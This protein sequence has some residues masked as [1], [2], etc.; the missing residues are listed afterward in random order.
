MQINKISPNTPV[1]QAKVNS[2]KMI[3]PMLKESG[4]DVFVKGNAPKAAVT[5]IGAILSFFGMGEAKPN[6]PDVMVDLSEE[7]IQKMRAKIKDDPVFQTFKLYPEDFCKEQVILTDRILNDEK[8]RSDKSLTT[9]L[10]DIIYEVSDKNQLR[11]AN[12]IL[13]DEKLYGD[14]NIRK[15]ALIILST[16]SGEEETNIKCEVLNKYMSSEKFYGNENVNRN[17]IKMLNFTN[18][19]E[20][21]YVVNKLLDK[22]ELRTSKEVMDRSEDFIKNANTTERFEVINKVLDN[23][24]LHGNNDILKSVSLMLPNI[25]NSRDSQIVMKVLNNKDLYSNKYNISK[26]ANILP[27]IT[28]DAHEEIVNK[29]F[30]NRE[31]YNNSSLMDILPTILPHVNAPESKMIVD[32]ILDN[33]RLAISWNL[34]SNLSIILGY[35]KQNDCADSYVRILDK[36][37]NNKKLLENEA[38]RDS[39]G[40][41]LLCANSHENRKIV[42]KVLNNEKLYGNKDIVENLHKMLPYTPRDANIQLINEFL[43]DKKLYENNL[44][45]KAFPMAIDYVNSPESYDIL[46]RVLH[47]EK[48]R[49]NPNIMENIT[50]ILCYTYNKYALKLAERIISD[51]NIYNNSTVMKALAKVSDLAISEYR[52]N[53][54]SKIVDQIFDN[55]NLYEDTNII[56]NFGNILTYTSK[57]EKYRVIEKILNEERLYKNCKFDEV[58]KMLRKVET[59]EEADVACKLLEDED[60]SLDA[61]TDIMVR[62]KDPF[63]KQYVYDLCQN[64]KKMELTQQNVAFLCMPY[65]T[66]TPEQLQRLNKVAGKENVSKLN[67]NDLEMACQIAE[68]YGKHNINEISAHCKKDLLRALISS[69]IGLFDVSD[70]MKQMFP[71]VPKNAQEYCTLLPALVRSM[72]IETKSLSPAQVKEFDKLIFELSDSLKKLSDDEFTSLKITQEYTKDEFIKNVR[73]VVKMLP[74]EER[75]KFYDYYGFELHH[76]RNSKT[77]FSIAG[78]PANLNNGEKLAQIKDSAT[79]TVVE[80]LRSDVIRFSENNLVQCDNKD[81]EYSLNKILKFLPELHTAIGKIQHPTHSFDIFKHSLKVLQK[82]SQDEKFQELNDSDKKIMML[83]A[84]L[85]DITKLE[86]SVDKTHPKEGAFDAYY[87]A[88]KFGLTREEEIKLFK[89]TQ[90]HEWLAYVN[91]SEIQGILTERLKSVAFELQ[92]DNLLDMA[93]IFT[94][95]DL[96]AVKSTDVFHDTKVGAGRVDLYGTSRS[97]GELADTYAEKIRAYVYEL[98]KTQ[99][100]LPVTKFPKASRINEVITHVNPDGSTNIKGVYKDKDGLIV[101]KFNEV[102]DWELIGFPKSSSTKGFMTTGLDDKN[103]DIEV[104]TGNIK[105]FVHGLDYEEQL[106]KF[107]AFSMPD[108]EAL[109]SVSYAERP[110]SKYRFFRAQGVILDFDTKYIHGG[111]D[112]DAGS[113]CKKT[114]DDF[115]RRYSSAGVIG[116]NRNYVPDMLKK[117]TG[118]SDDEYIK[119]VSENRNK[120]FAEI[121]PTEIRDKVIK[122]LATMNSN[123]RKG[124]REYNEMYGSNP[125]RVMGVF[126]YKMKLGEKTENPIEYLHSNVPEGDGTRFGTAKPISTNQRTGFLR[127]YA[128]EHD[129]PMVFLGD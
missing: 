23:K 14:P 105:F 111:G 56:E 50:G 75:Q 44:V 42:R 65:T 18:T 77:G 41:I 53:V 123:R 127:K 55:K 28:T 89:L 68:M 52:V 88:Q 11:L 115:K 21:L 118:M 60:F 7:E 29:I 6:E 16:L 46:N 129:I 48:F 70:T 120:P 49:N 81:I 30:D 94:H 10:A 35:S 4:S 78:Y 47:D 125:E 36:I 108:S 86:G 51:E 38:L 72:G 19:E 39:L 99:P 64:Y 8:L 32:K 31:L 107:D 71:L 95:A 1:F 104:E 27:N 57:N 119:F 33:P 90:N 43:E 2:N 12:K 45:A 116:Y 124:N 22:K 113:G 54:M 91:T 76:N 80:C 128:C 102:E 106:K 61:I 74:R 84:L 34:L 96:K 121:K 79:K 63:R 109:L 87:I 59:E 112:S 82:I 3:R 20:R 62:L 117:A 66:A 69:N 15:D 100:F 122:E 26:V 5:L 24:K 9:D 98:Q 110:E 101:L 97:F 40:N 93:L 73:N 83:A 103:N 114:I 85:H 58:F 37:T 25:N 17:F 126:V 92:N 13:S 67:S